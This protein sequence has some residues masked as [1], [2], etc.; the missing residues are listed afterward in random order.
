MN[1]EK[2]IEIICPKCEYAWNYKGKSKYYTS[3][4][5]CRANIKLKQ[6]IVKNE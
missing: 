4:P 3:C 5:R 1:K 6:E 2:G